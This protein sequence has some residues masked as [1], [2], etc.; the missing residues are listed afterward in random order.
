MLTVDVLGVSTLG[1]LRLAGQSFFKIKKE[2]SRLAKSLATSF[3]SCLDV[4]EE[5][6]E[7][8]E[9]KVRSTKPAATPPLLSCFPVS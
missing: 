4:C 7:K 6:F 1:S 3:D 5:Y 2:F 8:P 9:N